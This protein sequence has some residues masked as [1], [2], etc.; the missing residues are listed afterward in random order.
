MVLTFDA[1][2]NYVWEF[3]T[4]ATS[5]WLPVGTTANHTYTTSSSCVYPESWMIHYH[6]QVTLS[7]WAYRVA[8]PSVA[9]SMSYG[10]AARVGDTIWLNWVQERV[11]TEEQ[12]ARL[13]AEAEARDRM[14]AERRAAQAEALTKAETLLRSVLSAAQWADY[15]EKGYFETTVN[16]RRYR[17]KKGIAGN[18]KLLDSG[19][20]E[21]RSYCIHP[22]IDLPVADVMLGQKLLLEADEREFLRIANETILIR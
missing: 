10:E 20:R 9:T 14:Y 12:V 16:D 6:T 3:D 17:I 22:R 11:Q 8:Y 4:E 2:A 5:M 15:K 1:S 18:V 13:R 21:M 7:E 19:G